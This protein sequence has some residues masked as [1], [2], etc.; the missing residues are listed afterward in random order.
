M[1]IRTRVREV[2]GEWVRLVCEEADR[3]ERCAGGGGCGLGATG[4]SRQRF[5]DMPQ[6][7]TI[8]PPLQAGDLV[9][10]SVDDGAIVR[11]AAASYLLPVAGLLAG[12]LLGQLT[13]LGDGVVLLAALGGVFACVCY[14][15]RAAGRRLRVGVAMRRGP[16]RHV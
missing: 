6:R 2:H 11:A 5:L 9:L 4:G 10:V 12:A 16:D 7:T 15:R 8:R 3:C 14:G 13:G 1:E